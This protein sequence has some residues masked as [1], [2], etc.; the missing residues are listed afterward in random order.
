MRK[1]WLAL[2]NVSVRIKGFLGIG[3]PGMVKGTE[4]QFLDDIHRKDFLEQIIEV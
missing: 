1:A 2:S 4:L 3:A